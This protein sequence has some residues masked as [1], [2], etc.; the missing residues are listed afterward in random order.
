ME[1]MH[2]VKHEYLPC[3]STVCSVRTLVKYGYISEL[4]KYTLVSAILFYSNF[5]VHHD[6]EIAYKIQFKTDAINAITY[7]WKKM[8]LHIL[9]L[10]IYFPEKV[11]NPYNYADLKHHVPS[12]I[13]HLH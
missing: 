1:Q 6:I 5:V 7:S 8:K 2:L 10:C 3:D 11:C 12:F 9:S 13:L 4:A